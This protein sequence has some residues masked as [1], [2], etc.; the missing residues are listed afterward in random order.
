MASLV[1]FLVALPLCIGIAAASGVP[2]SL[3]II[4]GIVGGIVV[5]FL[6]GSTFQVSGPAAGLAVLVMEFVT[7]HGIGMVGPVVLAAGLCQ[8]LLGL[9]RMG[10]LF[11]S[12][13]VSVV[14]GMLAGIGVPLMLGQAYAVMDTDQRGSAMENLTGL[15]DL[16]GDALDDPGKRAAL[17][18]GV[19]SIVLCFLWKKVPGPLGKMP[20]PLLVV[21][22][23]AAVTV[24]AGL[25]VET[26]KVGNLLDSV[27]VTDPAGFGELA[28]PAVLTMVVT[29]TVIASAESLFSAAAVDRMHTGPRT[30]YNAELTAQGVGNTVCGVFGALPMTAVIVRSSANVQAGARTRLSRILH[31]VWMLGFGLLLP[32]LLGMIPVAVLAGILVHAGWKLFNPA[33]FPAMWRSDRGEAVVMIV[34]TLAIVLTNLLEGVVAGL[35]VAIV[36]AAL[37]MSRITIR[38]TVDG[39]SARLE[40]KGNATFLRLPRLIEALESIADRSV[41]QVDATGL[42]H[43]D[44]ACRSQLESWAE[45]QRKAGSDRVDLFLPGAAPGGGK[46]EEDPSTVELTLPVPP[47][48]ASEGVRPYAPEPQY[49]HGYAAAEDPAHRAHPHD[50]P[51][52]PHDHPHD[53]PGHPAAHR[54][55]PGPAAHPG[56]AHDTGVHP[57]HPATTPHGRP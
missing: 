6:P 33:A 45:Q 31:G 54:H 37:R 4:T 48:T 25:D 50:H 1:V 7:E 38:R 9:L 56:H 52:H 20:A 41:V 55:H 34:T 30:K 32:G 49:S 36:L 8:I 3:G 26:V 10:R 5:G 29:F 22:L 17:L 28:D 16:V 11:Q 18:L 40:L 46:G 39:G 44:H 51:G 27:H 21:V 15:P 13:S 35:G 43:L 53:H 57:S 42:S 23:G 47:A 14:Q 2:A 19:M 12:I 24:L